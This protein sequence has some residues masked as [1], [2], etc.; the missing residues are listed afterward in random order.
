MNDFI[1]Q[2]KLFFLNYL[3]N[4]LLYMYLISLLFRSFVFSTDMESSLPFSN[5]NCQFLFKFLLR[6]INRS[7]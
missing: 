7:I 5:R 2:K 1:Y 6:L 3:T 4:K